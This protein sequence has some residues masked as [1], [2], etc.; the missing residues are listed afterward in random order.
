MRELVGD[1]WQVIAEFMLDVIKNET[2]RNAD[3]IE[4]AK[5]LADRGF[6]KGC[7]RSRAGV[8]PEDLLRD[9]FSKL[10]LEDLETIQAILEKYSPAALVESG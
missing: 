8:T 2:A 7:P 9:F 6:G 10:S 4:A 5:W 1:D 3:C